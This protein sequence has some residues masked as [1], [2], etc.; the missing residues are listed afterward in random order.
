MKLCRADVEYFPDFNEAGLTHWAMLNTLAPVTDLGFTCSGPPV[1]SSL[2]TNLASPH[3][4]PPLF[5]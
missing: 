2:P 3:H 4:L 1:N 5:S